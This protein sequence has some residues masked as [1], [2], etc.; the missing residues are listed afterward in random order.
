MR[1]CV[2]TPVSPSARLIVAITTR[3][4]ARP[5]VGVAGRLGPPL[6]GEELEAALRPVDG[7]AEQLRAAAGHQAVGI[8]AV[9][10]RP[11]PA[12]GRR[13]RTLGAWG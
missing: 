11:G 9:R 10:Q 3:D 13:G 6:E 4:G 1:V 12:A 7:L 5:R 8:D 2:C